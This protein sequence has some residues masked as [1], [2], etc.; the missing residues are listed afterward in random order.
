MSDKMIG[1]IGECILGFVGIIMLCILANLLWFSP[2]FKEVPLIVYKFIEIMFTVMVVVEIILI[3][4]IIVKYKKMSNEFKLNKNLRTAQKAY[5]NLGLD[6]TEAVFHR[7]DNNDI[8][9]ITPQK[10]LKK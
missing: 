10:Q 6:A 8:T 7:G 2:E 5:S 1:Y 4:V 9:H 3:A